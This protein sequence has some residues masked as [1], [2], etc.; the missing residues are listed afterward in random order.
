M[1][2]LNEFQWINE[3]NNILSKEQIGMRKIGDRIES[4]MDIVLSYLSS[5]LTVLYTIPQTKLI[6]NNY[7]K[8]MEKIA[9]ASKFLFSELVAIETGLKN[10]TV[11]LIKV[12]NEIFYFNQID[13]TAFKESEI[14]M[15]QEAYRN[16]M[17][18]FRR[19]ARRFIHV[20]LN[21]VDLHALRH[22]ERPEELYYP[23]YPHY[24]YP[25]QPQFRYPQ[26]QPQGEVGEKK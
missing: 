26:P 14:R 21:G 7:L 17:E 12:G 16:M 11:V 3:V 6:L 19:L 9:M 5:N 23:P 10:K 22:E 24:G 1:P 13:K 25:P 4:E 15:L 20:L 8:A 2:G 18:A